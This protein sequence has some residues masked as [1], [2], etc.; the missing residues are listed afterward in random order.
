MVKEHLTLATSSRA[1]FDLSESNKV[2][3]Q[4]GLKKYQQYQID[5]ENNIL[6]QGSA[7]RLIKKL[8][9]LNTELNKRYIEV[10]LVSRNSADTG[11]RVFK[12]IAHYGL[13]IKR[14]AFTSGKSP[15]KYLTAFACDLF[16]SADIEDVKHALK[17]GIA[18]A[19]LI[20]TNEAAAAFISDIETS[21]LTNNEIRIAF[22][23]DAVLFS[24]ESEKIFQQQGLQAF[25]QNEK[26]FSQ[27]ELSA[28]PFQPFL[29]ILQKIQD[30]YEKRHLSCP[31]RTALVTARGAPT[32]ER[33]IYTLRKQGIRL[34]ETFFLS[35][36]EKTKILEAF[37]ADMFFDDGLNHCLKASSKVPSGHVPHGI[38]NNQ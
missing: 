38:N 24:D 22:D 26:H 16:L 11:M 21:E 5:N 33:V 12:S 32:L 1:L 23:G 29:K 3:E 13:D 27:Q 4:E 9:T 10:I 35:G 31:I 14:A 30:E 17:S 37:G 7:F 34:D 8:L 19:R 15:A 6:N 18:A 20:N 28:G 36:Y 2:F 25:E